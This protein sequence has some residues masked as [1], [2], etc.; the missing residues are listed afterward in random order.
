MPVTAAAT[1]S[2]RDAQARI[3]ERVRPLPLERLSLARVLGRVLGRPVSSRVDVPPW[4][5]SAMDGYA[6]RASDVRKDVPMRVVL[7]LPAG[8]PS[9]RTLEPGGAARIMTGGPLPRGA[10][11][12]IPVELSVGPEGPGAFAELGEEVRF[13]VRPSPGDH[14]RPR[15]EDVR[16]GQ[17][18][19][20]AGAVLRA[21]QIALA[22]TVGR[23]TVTVHRRP[24]VA[25]VSTGDELVDVEE[26]GAPDRIVDGNSWG[27]AA[28]VLEAGG[29]PVLSPR[30][31]DDPEATRE[32]VGAALSADAVVTL[33]GVSVGARDQVR[34]ALEEA[35]VT[36]DFWRVAVR[37]GGP[38]AFGTGADDRPVFALPGNPVSAFVTF[39]LF[40]RPALLRLQGHARCFRTPLQARLAEPVETRPGKAH[41]LRGRLEREGDGWVATPTGPQGSAILSGLAAADGLIVV[42][43]DASGRAAGAE[44]EVLPL[45][46]ILVAAP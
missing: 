44:V 38:I 30:V 26:A 20:P 2:V 19:L 15:G 46:E 3:L 39:E 34:A 33:G 32:A 36:L 10:D 42:P 31:P 41:Y 45:H 40:A 6:A 13:T 23:A 12:V 11:T 1:L 35:G 9:E 7:D 37:P 14:V 28:L 21:P 25:I 18:A 24:R 4:D 29:E 27:V 16:R 8:A 5:N 43:A 22:A 17:V